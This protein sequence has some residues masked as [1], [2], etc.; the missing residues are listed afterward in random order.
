MRA[1]EILREYSRDVTAQRLGTALLNMFK[2]EGPGWI[3][4]V[5]G[6]DPI[7]GNEEQ[8]IEFILN[9][10]EEVDPSPNKQYVQWLAR[11]YAKGGTR[12]E[13]VLSQVAPYLEKFYKLN[14]RK[15]IPVPRNDIGGY[16]NFGDFMSVMDEYPDVDPKPLTDKG[17]A[18]QLY[19]DNTM[20]V[21]IPVDQTAACYYGQG[22]RWCTAA[23]RGRNYFNDYSN[24][25]PL[26]IVIPTKPAHPGEK[27]QLHFNYSI[28]D[29]PIHSDDDYN[30]LYHYRGE[31]YMI[32]N[33]VDGQFMDEKDQPVSLKSLKARFGASFDQMI[34]TYLQQFPD[35]TYR[36]QRNFEMNS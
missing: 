22:T 29:N 17:Q 4:R 24:D 5:W 11:T 9:R 6:D 2:K 31:D 7:E 27:Y 34:D 21:I 23:T 35:E 26:L 18:E 16:T 3:N 10:L 20:R 25:A 19:S 15:Q 33:E 13:D 14:L 12:F 30:E 36:V 28:G 32:D 8:V 1:V